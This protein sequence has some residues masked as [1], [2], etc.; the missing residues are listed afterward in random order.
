VIALIDRR[1][2]RLTRSKLERLF[3]PI[4]VRAGYPVPLTRQIVNGFEVDFHWPELKIVVETDG[5]TYH[6]TAAQQAKDLVR[7]QAHA[8]ANLLSLRF[9]HEQIAYEP[10][11][12]EAI[13]R[14]V[15]GRLPAA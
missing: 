14:R 15:R 8:A 11:Y 12:V 3:I 5:L 4:A 1:T 13:L 9:S 7:D 2:F 10:A 6:R